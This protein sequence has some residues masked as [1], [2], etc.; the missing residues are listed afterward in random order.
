MITHYRDREPRVEDK[1]QEDR[2]W[3]AAV[4]LIAVGLVLLVAQFTNSSFTAMLVL[5]A[6]ALIFLAWGIAA[7]K[8][9]FMIPAGIFIGLSLGTWLITTDWIAANVNEETQGGIFLLAFAAGWAS[10]TIL[11]W[12]FTSDLHWWPLIPGGIMA[13]VGGALLIGGNA[14]QALVWLGYA[15]P[16]ALVAAGIFLLL[17]RSGING[18]M[19]R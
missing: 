6:L 11:S 14:L 4:G 9:A 5:P 3:I 18:P 12:L 15:W 13:I 19:H 8:S 10:I 7:H 1:A 17:R 16:I 2:G